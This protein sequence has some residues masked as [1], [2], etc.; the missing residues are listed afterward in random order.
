MDIENLKALMEDC[1]NE[2]ERQEYRMQLKELR[3]QSIRRP[4]AVAR[5]TATQEQDSNNNIVEGSSPI[6]S[7]TI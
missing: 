5:L 3:K 2:E 7:I 4:E 1:D 6:S